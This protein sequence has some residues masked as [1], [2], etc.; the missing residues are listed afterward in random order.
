MDLRPFCASDNWFPFPFWTVLEPCTLSYWLAFGTCNENSWRLRFKSPNGIRHSLKFWS[1]R[2]LTPI[3]SPQEFERISAKFPNRNPARIKNSKL[4][5]A[6]AI[7]LENVQLQNAT[8]SE[9]NTEF[10]FRAR[11]QMNNFG[12]PLPQGLYD[13]QHCRV[14]R[15]YMVPRQWL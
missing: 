15:V 2:L 8:T 10:V 3:T 14:H 12:Y 1:Y 5:A 13:P 11:T 4:Y 9:L 6:D 7:G